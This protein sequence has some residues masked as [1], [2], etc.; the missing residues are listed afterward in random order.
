MARIAG[1]NI[2]DDKRI[3]VSLTY[4]YGIG[5]TTSQIILA[6]LKIDETIRVKDLS[7]EQMNAIRSEIADN[8]TVDAD[9]RRENQL[10][11]KRLMEIGCYRGIRHRLGLPVRGQGTKNN[12]RTRKGGKKTVAGKKG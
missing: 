5:L 7:E 11:V 12:A 4:V 2:P 8:Y 9:L 6:K 1:V 3:M 10:S